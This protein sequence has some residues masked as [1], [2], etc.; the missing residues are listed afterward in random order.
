V[1]DLRG[2]EPLTSPVREKQ[3][4]IRLPGQTSDFPAQTYLGTSATTWEFTPTAL[5]TKEVPAIIGFS[6]SFAITAG[7]IQLVEPLSLQADAWDEHVT[8]LSESY[9]VWRFGAGYSDT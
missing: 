9:P 4:A 5:M 8:I 2:V 6:W 1:V 7:E 3:S